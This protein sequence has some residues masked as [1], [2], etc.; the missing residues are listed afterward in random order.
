MFRIADII[1]FGELKRMRTREGE[2][3]RERRAVTIWATSN[4]PPLSSMR[5]HDEPFGFQSMAG[6]FSDSCGQPEV[7]SH[8]PPPYIRELLTDSRNSFAAT[9]LT[10]MLG[11]RGRFLGIAAGSR[12]VVASRWLSVR[13]NPIIESDEIDS[14][15]CVAVRPITATVES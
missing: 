13:D 14:D 15:C 11:Q 9:C 5:F 4:H 1:A 6:P 12:A 3:P 7:I 10:D 8:A 2:G